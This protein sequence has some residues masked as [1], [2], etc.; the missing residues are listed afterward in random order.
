MFNRAPALLRRRRG[1]RGGG[2]G[3]GV[4]SLG[5][6]KGCF[7]RGEVLYANHFGKYLSRCALGACRLHQSLRLGRAS[8]LLSHCDL[9]SLGRFSG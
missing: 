5:A 2:V 8:S 4:L 7:F 9:L 1:G 3:V 6:G